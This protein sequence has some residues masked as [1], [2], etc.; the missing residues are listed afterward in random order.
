MWAAP[1][2][3]RGAGLAS[4]LELTTHNLQVLDI[5]VHDLMLALLSFDFAFVQVFFLSF[6]PFR[7]FTLYHCMLELQEFVLDF[8]G[9]FQ[10]GRL[11]EIH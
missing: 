10:S 8:R 9:D 1:S 3:D 4:P 5:E 7:I 11:L 2:K 6:Y